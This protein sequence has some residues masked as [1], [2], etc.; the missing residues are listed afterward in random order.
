MIP[1]IK[2]FNTQNNSTYIVYGEIHTHIPQTYKNM[3]G[4]V[5]YQT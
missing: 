3:H 5:K 4:N 1:F 2:M